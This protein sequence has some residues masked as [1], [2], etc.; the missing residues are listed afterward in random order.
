MS[1]A[2][3]GVPLSDGAQPDGARQDGAQPG[4]AQP[5]R[6]QL[7]GVWGAGAEGRSAARTMLDEGREVLVVDE[8]PGE[9]PAELDE[10]A[11]YASGD[12]AL[13]RLLGVG[14][15]VCSPGVPRTHPFREQLAAAGV[16]AT[17]LSARWMARA[18]ASTI[19]VTGT[20][21][22]STTATLTSLLL[23]AAGR[24]VQVG[25]NIGV[26]LAEMREGVEVTVA[27]L[28]SYQCA[29]LEHG[30]RIAI[31][32]SLYSD[33]LPWHG[34]KA[35]YWQDK[36]GI[37]G[38][39]C[40]AVVCD[41]DTL[42]KLRTVDVALPAEILVP[43]AALVDRVAGLGL[44]GPIALAQ[45]LRNLELAILAVE[46]WLGRP[47]ADDEIRAAAERF[48][49]LPH[50]LETIAV[51]DGVTWV[52]DTLA[53]VPEG[54]IAALEAFPGPV[55][56]IV[57]G[58]DRGIDFAVLTEFLLARAPK[59]RLITIPTSGRRVAEG[60]RAAHPELVEDAESL[61]AAV[62]RAAQLAAE[63]A[64]PGTAV[65]LS[66][67]S[68]SYDFYRNYEDKSEAFARAVAALG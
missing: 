58:E 5:D 13:E 51:R 19:G 21:G 68:P 46:R 29:Y 59:A 44:A 63:L 35:Q 56:A 45:N 38:P 28:S 37:V 65:L 54:V 12:G 4:R 2:G 14:L 30:P 9:R 43:Q 61:E 39:G 10:R 48:T 47:L 20:K 57:G 50:R 27:E 53:T 15:V 17:T 64:E 8:R 66:P 40:E 23:E 3:T 16:P 49:P 32:T 42:A 33:H 1:E 18:G 26:P 24:E 25:G 31:V 22:K 52:D 6:A 7:V 36:S 62:A 55:I 67:G 41:E 60:Y 11:G 34:S